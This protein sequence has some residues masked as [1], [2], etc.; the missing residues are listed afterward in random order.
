MEL[1]DTL[2][3][4]NKQSDKTMLKLLKGDKNWT[5]LLVEL[6]KQKAHGF[7]PHPKME[8]LISLALRHFVEADAE[9]AAAIVRGEPIEGESKVMVFVQFRD[10]VDEII[11]RLKHHHPLIRPTPFIGQGTDKRGNKG[12]SQKEQLEVCIA[13]FGTLIF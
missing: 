5:A 3:T 11:D 9:A 8:K 4:S 7:D 2:S 12:I 1:Q 10:C 13:V 6:E